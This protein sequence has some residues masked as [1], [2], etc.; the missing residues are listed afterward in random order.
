MVHEFGAK[1]SKITG[2][3]FDLLGFDPRG[4]GATLPRA[5]CFSS[6]AESQ[7]W[8]LQQGPVL[9]LS[10]NSIPFARSRAQLLSA[11]C[12]EALGGND[13]D[14]WAP[15]RYMGTASVATDM[16][17]IVEKLGQ[18]KLQYWGI[19]CCLLPFSRFI[20]LMQGVELRLRHRPVLRGDVPR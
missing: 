11:R 3:E 19:V 4:T 8:D 16:L 13:E 15:G 14:E 6:E 18:D 9:N 17:H 7:I 2:P 12:R 5:D 10:D 20:L 1:I